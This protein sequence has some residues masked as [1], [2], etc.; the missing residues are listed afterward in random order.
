MNQEKQKSYVPASLA[1]LAAIW[2][3]VNKRGSLLTDIAH[4]SVGKV[5]YGDRKKNQYRNKSKSKKHR[6]RTRPE[7]AK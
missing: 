5:L 1:A 3:G 6:G 2:L 7:P 4:E